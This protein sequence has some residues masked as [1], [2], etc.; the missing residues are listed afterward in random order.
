VDLFFCLSGFVLPF[1]Y[2][3][4]KASVSMSAFSVIRLI[5]LMPLLV[6]ALAISAAYVISRNLLGSGVPYSSVVIG[7]VLGLLN[8]PYFTAPKAIGGPQVFP[9]N[10]PQYTICLELF[11]NLVWWATRRMNQLRLALVLTVL[12][13]SILSQTGLAGDLPQNFW[14][15]LPR[16]G[17]SFFAG[18]ASFHLS[19]KLTSWAGWT[20]IFWL[21]S[22]VMA[23]FF[24]L[25]LAIPLSMQ[26]LWVA[27]IS[28]LLVIAGSRVA[29]TSKAE[30]LALKLGALS[31]PLYALHYPLFC[32]INGS[33]KIWVHSQSLPVEGA[34]VSSVTVILSFVALR[35]YDEP[36]RRLLTS[37]RTTTPTRGSASG[38]LTF[39]LQ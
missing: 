31:Y 35:Y 1:A 5:R 28:P 22:T 29:L 26:L 14:S 39:K 12:S 32:W 19:S 27:L 9:L 36:L 2:G 25:P 38:Q 24:Y 30:L 11:V 10:G 37:M 18:V 21:L 34:L 6:L 4:K 3:Q 17:A 8:L 7:I 16:V 23:F 20:P 33:Y 15:G 13:V